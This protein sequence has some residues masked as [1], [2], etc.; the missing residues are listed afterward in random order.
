MT[1]ATSRARPYGLAPGVSY[2]AL[3]WLVG[4]GI[5][6]LTGAAAVVLVLASTVAGLLAALVEAWRAT[7]HARVVAVT[8][9]AVVTAGDIATVGVDL[10]GRRRPP[11]RF[12]LVVRS[13][14]R[15]RFGIGERDVVSTPTDVARTILV[16]VRF[17]EPGIVEIV[18]VDVET[19]GTS[20]LVWWR[21]RH[22]IAVA[23]I[24]VAPAPVGPR[25]P[26][27]RF[28]NSDPGDGSIRHGT[29]GGDVDGVRPWREGE[30]VVGVHWPSTLR[31]GSLVV[32]DRNAASDVTWVVPI[33]GPADA[34]RVRFT[35][36]EGLRAGHAVS[37]RDADPTGIA[38]VERVAD[39]DDA[40]RRSA[41]LAEGTR[42]SAVPA[43]A[44]ARSMLAREFHPFGNPLGRR[45]TDATAHASPGSDRSN[46]ERTMGVRS[47]ARW[48]TA[49][50]S[51]VALGMLVTALAGGVA[52]IV[53]VAV[54]LA[55]GA[56]VTVRYVDADGR[57]PRAVRAGVGLAAVGAL[58]YIA[59][60]ASGIG[61]LLA[62]L[63]GPLPDLLVLLVVLHGF[64][65]TTRRTMRVHQAI[66]LI[67][68]IYAAGLRIDDQLGWWLAAWGVTFV[69][70]I[71]LASSSPADPSPSS[72]R[73]PAIA[74][75]RHDGVRMRSIAGWS[76]ATA[77]C[78]L[79]LLLTVPIPDGPASLGLPAMSTGADVGSP[80][81]LAGPDGAL[82][83]SAQSD[84]TRG[85][86]GE[87]GGY[88]GFSE[89]LDTSVR[90]D[91]GSQVVMRVRA[92]EPAFWR[93]QTFTSFDGRT[94]AVSPEVGRA[95]QGPTIDVPPTLGDD[96]DP[97]LE[98]DELVQTYFV[99]ADLP[100][101]V[102]AAH[103]A[104]MVVFDGIVWTRPDGAL[105]SDV[106]LTQG[107]VYTVVSERVRV[108]ADLLRAQGDVAEVFAAFDDSASQAVLAPYL[109]LPP[110]TSARTVA[111][112]EELARP[113]RS[114]YDTVR[115]Y[116]AWI[117][118]N[119]A[120][121]LDAPIPDQGLDAVDDF[122]FV[123][124]RGFCEQIA[125]ALTVML[126]SQG[127]PARLA[128]GY[129]PGERDRVSGVWEVRAS[130]A[131]AWVEVWFPDS[132]W[133]A[134]DPTANVP[135]AGDA[136]VGSVGSDLLSAAF[137]GVMSR[138]VEVGSVVAAG[139]V[140]LAAVRF[141][142]ELR[143]RRRRGRWGLLQD[144]FTTLTAMHPDSTNLAIRTNPQRGDRLLSM[145][146]HGDGDVA[147]CVRSAITI[148]VEALDR[149]TFD[150]SWSEVDAG[151]QAAYDG[152]VAALATVERE[153]RRVEG[154][155][156]EP[157]RV[158]TSLGVDERP[159]VAR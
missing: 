12:R 74:G 51:G 85:S 62:A 125:S 26:F 154:V 99:E 81:A 102:F 101:V 23:P 87:V 60:D 30:G 59:V 4:L 135:L 95:R 78:A 1:A 29:G 9:P 119:T 39:A 24:H 68:A 112:A 79:A 155:G 121:D 20:G 66:A 142:I 139:L 21:R 48:T 34:G 83:S 132:G 76:V 100:N 96:A 67:V 50:T 150:P 14:P 134:F 16:D 110:S 116:E 109:E 127:V 158:G 72:A 70:A 143:R 32:H 105:R 43:P 113:G 138:P 122:L 44:R 35:L 61:G 94:W 2:F 88:P 114:T 41:V 152:A 108:T 73:L 153:L 18:H 140:G 141:V 53:L 120:Y 147:M 56:I 37:V 126:R 75:T 57:Q 107:S 10:V 22:T 13:D 146:D 130:D 136:V 157:A 27:E 149:V 123:S 5:A 92:P 129:L 71:T 106:T 159:R 64:E 124:Q 118:A 8:S 65:V 77:A 97:S 45:V 90:G 128:T 42:R 133:Q 156:R 11:R 47:A 28:M 131:H 115:A 31:S 15:D 82:A 148:V 55:L 52:M 6:R 151:S 40:A 86:L 36:E 58:A 3:T 19:A 7:G 137:S 144:R 117:A 93:G 111:L 104:T 17:D 54:G 49:L 145:F 46:P 69:A 80:G 63:R 98:R 103:R 89:T 38:T 25:V 33:D 91:L 84:G